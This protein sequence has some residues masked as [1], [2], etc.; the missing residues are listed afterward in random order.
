MSDRSEWVCPG[1]MFMRFMKSWLH[2]FR[3]SLMQQKGYFRKAK[4]EIKTTNLR[5]LKWL[6]I[7]QL[8]FL[9][10]FI[11]ITPPLYPGWT[12]TF[13]YR[14]FVVIAVG[15]AVLIHL[16]A[17]SKNIT[18][19]TVLLLCV[20]F[21]AEV[22]AGCMS[23]D[24]MPDPNAQ[25]V[26][27][28]I[29]LVVMPSLLV[30]PLAGVFSLT[31][32]MEALYLVL[33][34]NYKTPSVAVNDVYRSLIG[35]FCSLV[36]MVN[37]CDLRTREGLSK[38]HY[39]RQGTTDPLTRVHNRAECELQIRDFFRNRLADEPQCALLMFDVDHFKQVNDSYG[40][41]KGDL[42]LSEVGSVL[43]EGF[44]A[45][46]VI[47]RIG[48]DEFMVLLKTIR[49]EESLRELAERTLN[50]IR[51]LSGKCGVEVSCS[52]G[53]AELRGTTAA[54]ETMY[55]IADQAMYEAKRSGMGR[56]VIRQVP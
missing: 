3:E 2:M 42:I 17:R 20:L 4:E 5:L 11:L 31:V 21:Y 1:D 18:P 33:V 22:L 29:M 25:S 45:D 27:Y 49:N 46:D 44:R 36:V 19:D 47:G 38:Y 12:P 50:N 28:P 53:I 15:A 37:V 6:S 56:Y 35:F 41:Q 13:P 24:I 16:Y 8:F 10:F 7:I 14:F 40:H 34:I 43:K 52:L 51:Y 32:V 30:M 48:G 39:I 26:Y 9:A 55:Q 54:Y 23:V